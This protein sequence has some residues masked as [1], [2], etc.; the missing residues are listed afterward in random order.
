LTRSEVTHLVVIGRDTCKDSAYMTIYRGL[1]NKY[2][3]ENGEKD[4]LKM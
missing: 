3:E 1:S 2:K 4:E